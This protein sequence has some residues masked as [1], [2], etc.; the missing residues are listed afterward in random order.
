ML[1]LSLQRR[2]RARA[3]RERS[4]SPARAALIA[5]TVLCCAATT[6]AQ[7]PDTLWTRTFGGTNI[8]ICHDVR[9]TADGGFILTG[10]TRSSG[11]SGRNVW[12][13]KT[14]PSG[15]AEWNYAFGGNSDDEGHSVWQ[16][17]DGGYIAAGLTSSFG[18]GGKDV[19]LVKTDAAGNEDWTRTFGGASDD[20]A[21]AVQE[22]DDG[23]L[24]VAGVTSSFGAGSRDVW[25]IKTDAAGAPIWTRTL[26]GYGSD[27]AWSVSQTSDRGFILSGW[28]FSH[29]PGYL[30]NAWL[31]KTDSLGYLDWHETFGGTEADRGYW[32][33]QTAD[34]GYIMTGYTD[35]FG[36]GLYDMLLVKTDSE[37]TAEWLETF[38]GSGRDYGN[39]VVQTAD[40]GYLA[41]GYTLSY[42]AGGDDV[43][44]VRTDAD[45]NLDW[46]TTYGGS[47][48]DVAY[49][50]AN[51]SDGGYAVAGH[52]LS[53]GAGLHDGWLI[54]LASDGASSA[55]LPT[56]T[57]TRAALGVWPNPFSRVAAIEYTLPGAATV[58]LCIHDA[59]GR[60]VRALAAGHAPAGSRTVLWD[61]CSQT[62]DRVPP[63]LYYCRLEAGGLRTVA[64]MVRLD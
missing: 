40:G 37:G 12:L 59:G 61:G 58:R 13:V 8:D 33:R 21:Y 62:G 29:G 25:L 22:T 34:G 42:G 36:A 47:A 56:I 35:S 53:F 20:E 50:V 38:G 7:P 51:T 63:G 46:Q 18:A 26:G 17:S 41:A 31:V 6:L 23:G 32:V 27:G 44:L 60:L 49:A 43:W 14:D 24:I 15:A 39:S 55:D 28:T 64:K 10:Y 57:A 48:S 16:T 2:P 30:G 9:Q 19:W 3:S 11:P 54:R 1:H 52:T 4:A 45:G 5:A